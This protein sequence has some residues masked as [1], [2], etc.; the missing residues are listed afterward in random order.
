MALSTTARSEHLTDGC[1]SNAD[2]HPDG[3]GLADPMIH[4]AP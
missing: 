1:V 4:H 3:H 2:A